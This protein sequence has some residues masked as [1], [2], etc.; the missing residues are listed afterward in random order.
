[1]TSD[2][3]AP[4]GSEHGSAHR[5]GF[6]NPQITDFLPRDTPHIVINGETLP[7]DSDAARATLAQLP[8][9]KALVALAYADRA[10]LV[11]SGLVLR[12]AVERLLPSA[13]AHATDAEMLADEAGADPQATADERRGRRR[14]ADDVQ[15]DITFALEALAMVQGVKP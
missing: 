4:F 14:H 13:E 5:T 6:R 10:A 8:T 11:L 2:E 12:R 15:A 9:E 7:S 1:M 3:Q